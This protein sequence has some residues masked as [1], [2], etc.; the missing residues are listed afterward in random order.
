MADA[1]PRPFAPAVDASAAAE[2]AARFGPPCVLAFADGRCLHPALPTT[3]AARDFVAAHA[4]ADLYFAPAVLRDAFVG[5]P[6]KGDCVGA[7]WAWVDIDPPKNMRDPVALAEWRAR[8]LA[9]IDAADLPPP[10]IVVG[11]GRGLWLFWHLSRRVAPTEAEAIN[12]ALAQAFGADA[13]HNIDRVARLPGTRNRK[14]G[15]VAVI[16][17]DTHGT[18]D[19]DNL[20]HRV[21]TGTALA[22]ENAPPPSVGERLASLDD[23]D[24]W[25]VPSRVR[26]IINQGH[27]PDEPKEGDN[28]RSAWLFDATCQLVRCEVPDDTIMAI[29]TDPAFGIS[30]SVLDKGS[31]GEAYAARQIAQAKE[32]VADPLLAEL[33]ELHFVVENDGGKCRVA[34]WVPGEDG[35]EQLSFQSFDDFRNRCMNRFAQIGVDKQGMPVMKPIGAWWLAHPRRRQFRGLVFR[36]G[37]PATVGGYLNL[38]RGY[39]IPP[40]PGDWSLMRAHI[41]DVLASGDPASDDYIL[42]WAAWAVQHPDQPAEVALVFRGGMGTGKG[43]FARAMAR[44][45]G[46]HGLQVTAPGQFAGRFNSHLRDVC[47]LFADEA[48]LPDDRTARGIL[49]ALL[50]EPTLP[51][52]GKGRDIVQAPNFVKV[53][54]ASNEK[55]V[56]PTD[57][58]DRRFAVFQVSDIHKQDEAYY[59][60]L[61]AEMNGGGLAAMLH[62]LLAMPLNGWHPRRDIP[63]TDARREQKAATLSGFD[64]VFLDLLREGVVPAVRWPGVDQPFVSTKELRDLAAERDRRADVS[65][66]AVS[67]LLKGLG[68]EK[69][70]RSRPS[71]FV[72]PTLPEARAAWDHARSPVAWDDTDCW[73]DLGGAGDPVRGAF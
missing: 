25:Q 11:S 60:A 18:I 31:K 6:K 54:M 27:H 64:A 53:I 1:D 32:K 15:A 71:G 8:T 52:E 2:F 49:K 21:P 4:D 33:N 7:E 26:V 40:A 47:L 61:N 70:R 16:L 20:P 35:R 39:G 24:R 3:D 44:L 67:D 42:R 43:T 37:G 14:T 73:A 55:W 58:D 46:Q 19:P 10:H 38:W 68:F 30:A 66:N 17:R 34:E 72:L 36:P 62:D 56:V 28:S 12:Y 5:K 22:P 65:Y 51:I 23:L 29:L 59:A 45:F 48:V 63:D 9:D 13:C 69:V 41:R 57:M 50:T